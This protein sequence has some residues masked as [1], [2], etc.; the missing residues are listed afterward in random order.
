MASEREKRSER[1]M[2]IELLGFELT[3]EDFGVG[4]L[5]E[6]SGFVPDGVSLLLSDPE[7]VHGHSGAEERILRPSICSYDGHPYNEERA[8]QSWTAGDLKRLVATLQRAG[9][10]VFFTHFDAPVDGWAAGHPEMCFINRRGERIPFLCPYKRLKDGT[11]YRDFYF[12]RLL[13]VL[14]D[15]GFDGYHAGDGY[16]HPR[17]PIYEG[18]FSD[19]T[20]G[21]YLDWAGGER[22]DWLVRDAEG[23][24]GA[25]A[26]RAERIG[27]ELRRS[28]I[29]FQRQRTLDF[30][31]RLVRLVHGEGRQI[32][33]NSCWT[34]DPF[35][36]LYRYG[37]DY[38]ALAA[39]GVDGFFAETAA[40]VHEYGGDLPY[41]E[42][43][44]DAWEPSSIL[45]R[46]ATQLLLLRAAVPKAR[47]LFM[48]GIKDTNEA[49][50]GIRHAP[51][52]L[53]SEILTFKGLFQVGAEGLVPSSDGLIAT[54]S[55]S[56]RREDWGWLR[57]CWDLGDALRPEG[58]AGA[59]IYW[60]DAYPSRMVEDYVAVRRCPLDRILWKMIQSGAPL[61]ATVRAE[62][63]ANWRGVLVVAHPH[64]LPGEE[65]TRLQ[66]WTGGALVAV[67]GAAPRE[68]RNPDFRERESEGGDALEISVYGADSTGGGVPVLERVPG[69]EVFDAAGARDPFQWLDHLPSRRVAP[70]F[71]RNAAR[72]VTAL[73]GGVRVEKNS[74]DVRAWAYRLGGGRFRVHVRNDGFYYRAAVIRMPEPI[75]GIRTL[76]DFPGNPVRFEGAVF[77]F[78]I[79][80]KSL[81]VFEVESVV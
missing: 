70:E 63:L 53:E 39:A 58:I 30:W 4:E 42:E 38:Q 52:N 17:V 73:S 40:A 5:F 75:G 78:K 56:L 49:W 43:G 61:V 31:S 12:D 6:R 68:G 66:D 64:L 28:W 41:G 24:A 69:P 60:S 72:W 57:R 55:D 34:R 35:E 15:Y 23:D 27:G 11:H 2:W 1:W 80:G 32:F 79:A 13:A 18:D 65:W 21:Q 77:R 10:R 3:A 74:S 8:L 51:V 9:T 48:N 29:A 20:V 25:L 14:R 7:F 26:E 47:I 81:A 33:L 44:Y 76:T 37:V 46:F 19:D 67:G 62:H 22:P 54:L 71:F 16:A 50:S 59:A 36:A 45:S